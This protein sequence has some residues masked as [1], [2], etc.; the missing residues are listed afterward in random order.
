MNLA[1]D[2]STRSG[3]DVVVFEE[4]SK[5]FEQPLFADVSFTVNWQDHLAIVGANGTGKSTLLKMITGEIM[6]DNGICRMGSNVKLGYLSQK[7]EYEN[8]ASRVMD[9]FRGNINMTEGEARHVL[10]SFLFFGFDVFKKV[11]DLSS[12]EKMRLRLAQLMYEEVNVLI[13]DEP[14][15]HLD[16][17]SREV[18]EKRFSNLKERYLRYRMIVIF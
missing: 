14:T 8:P 16:I 5:T 3:K 12:G 7:F 13:L 15:N 10:A 1:F 2:V 6:P 17:E 9:V 11:R 4:V 18:L